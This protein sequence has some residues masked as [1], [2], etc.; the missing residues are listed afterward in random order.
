MMRAFGVRPPDPG[1]RGLLPVQPAASGDYEQLA[2]IYHRP[3][4][5][6]RAG[7]AEL[8]GEQLTKQASPM[9]PTSPK[10]T[11][12]DQNMPT[13]SAH[14]ALGLNRE[15]RGYLSSLELEPLR[16]ASRSRPM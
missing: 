14:E 15:R 1:D 13:T 12:P 6:L 3:R 10:R 11:S 8:S 16:R 7:T 2:M 9:R 5:A 4:H